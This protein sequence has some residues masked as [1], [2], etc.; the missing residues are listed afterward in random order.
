MHWV[1]VLVLSSC[2]VYA[3]SVWVA[4]AA[5]PSKQVCLNTETEVRATWSKLGEMAGYATHCVLEEEWDRPQG[6]VFSI[7][8]ECPEYQGYP[9]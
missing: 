3:D 4:T 5:L 9:G 8:K 6:W 7:E 1:L 2:G